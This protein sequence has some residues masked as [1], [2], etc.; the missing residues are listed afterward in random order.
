MSANDKAKNAAEQL[1]GRAKATAG[2]AT[3]DPEMELEGRAKEKK[4]DLKQ[5]VE[6]AK[7]AAGGS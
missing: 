2:A 4:A 6:K 1:T 3:D 5:A 7:D